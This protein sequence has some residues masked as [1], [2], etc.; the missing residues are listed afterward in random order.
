M[1]SSVLSSKQA[2][3]V[4]IQTVRV[5]TKLRELLNEH[6]DLKLEI[7]DIKKQLQN[8]D[9]NIEL[10]FSYIDELTEKKAKPRR[11]IGYKP[12]EL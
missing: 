8:H 12:D 11:R 9:K 6:S 1:L 2:I 4:N 7:S 3:Q 10:V 5:F